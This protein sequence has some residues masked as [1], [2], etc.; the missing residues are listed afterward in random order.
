[1]QKN[2]EDEVSSLKIKISDANAS[3]KKLNLAITS[4]D[5]ISAE[6]V[7]GSTSLIVPSS[8]LSQTSYSPNIIKADS[9]DEIFQIVKNDPLERSQSS[10]NEIEIAEPSFEILIKPDSSEGYSD[11]II[12]N[13]LENLQSIIKD[14]SSD[15]VVNW[16]KKVLEKENYIA[17]YQSSESGVS[18]ES[19]SNFDELSIAS[20][21]NNQEISYKAHLKLSGQK[22]IIENLLKKLKDKKDRI[23]IN[24]QHI[25]TLQNEIR[26]LD[27]KLKKDNSFDI[28]YLRTSVINFAKTLKKLEKDSV[29]MLSIIF[30]QLGLNFDEFINKPEKKK[31]WGMFLS[32]KE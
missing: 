10:Y 4:T 5:S 2:Y 29:T 20:E 19:K 28:E 17:R 13:L 12:S 27:N 1:M 23:N 3:E 11:T 6:R 22:K 24:K 31:I 25:K 30:S 8:V 9:Y 14:Q 16:C 7:F 26:N 18:D 15:L 21:Y 32:K